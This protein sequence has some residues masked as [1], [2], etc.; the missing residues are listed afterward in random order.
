M[1]RNGFKRTVSV[2]EGNKGPRLSK[3]HRG[4]SQDTDSAD[5]VTHVN[6]PHH[7]SSHGIAFHLGLKVLWC[8]GWREAGWRLVS[9]LSLER[10]V[11]LSK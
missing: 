8:G 1:F 5:W 4:V 11:A 9:S 3:D 7:S 10:G 6:R 2:N